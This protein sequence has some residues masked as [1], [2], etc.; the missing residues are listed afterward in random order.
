MS[1][2]V[3]SAWNHT[4]SHIELG[5]I[6]LLWTI[7]AQLNNNIILLSKDVFR[8]FHEGLHFRPPSHSPRTQTVLHERLGW[9]KSQMR[10][11]VHYSKVSF[12][13]LM[14]LS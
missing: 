5:P 7:L 12:S 10:D 6:P 3:L 1:S 11:S 4:L 2:G 8:E 9:K 13:P 14:V